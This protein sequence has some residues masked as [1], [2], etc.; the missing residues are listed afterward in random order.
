MPDIQELYEKYSDENSDV[1]V[2]GIAAPGV[3]NEKS[4]E[5]IIAFLEENGY[6][7]PVLMDEGGRYFRLLGIMSYPTTY[8]ITKEGK[9]FGYVSGA[10]SGDIMEDIIHQTR[11]GKRTN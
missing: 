10:I 8:M 4:E 1:V 11:E 5:E 3:G 9:I 6:N 7:Y 2:L